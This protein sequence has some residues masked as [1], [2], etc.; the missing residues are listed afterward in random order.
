MRPEIGAI[1]LQSTVLADPSH[2][3]WAM[4]CVTTVPI[5]SYE[6]MTSGSYGTLTTVV[7]EAFR[8]DAAPNRC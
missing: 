5:G 8:R 6:L 1:L 2:R 3:R 4:G 7:F